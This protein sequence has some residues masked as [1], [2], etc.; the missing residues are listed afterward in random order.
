M[1]T[2]VCVGCEGYLFNRETAGV[3]VVSREERGR[4]EGLA[5][6]LLASLVKLGYA[7][8]HYRGQW[9]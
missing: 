8:T 6:I 2:K 9:R 3:R 5:L 1:K 7:V 4:K